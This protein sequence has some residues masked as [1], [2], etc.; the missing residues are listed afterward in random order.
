M[1]ISIFWHKDH[2]VAMGLFMVAFQIISSYSSFF[3]CPIPGVFYARLDGALS[4]PI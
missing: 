2:L 1:F 3:I 4:S